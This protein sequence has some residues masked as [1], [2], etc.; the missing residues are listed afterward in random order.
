[1]RVAGQ[2]AP[3]DVAGLAADG[4]TRIVNNRPDGEEPGQPTGA[5]IEAAALAAGIAY[6]YVPV[7]SGFSAKQVQA[8]AEATEAGV[9]LAFC[10]SGTRSVLLWALARARAGDDPQELEAKATMAGY[11]LGPVR[12]Y[13]QS[14]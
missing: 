11:D 10:K 14:H 5:A 4:V 9:T 3:E 8:M 1:M 7:A 6:H 13:L 12:A 2:I